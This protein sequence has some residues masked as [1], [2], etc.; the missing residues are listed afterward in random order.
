MSLAGG[1]DHD[2]VILGAGMSGI[3]MGVMLKRAG[4]HD[5]LIL[6]EA[7]GIGGTW[8]HNRYPGA[9]CDVPSHL[10]CFS[11]APNPDWSRV[12]ATG[13]EIQRYAVDCV[14]K[15]DLKKHLQLGCRIES[16]VFNAE[17]K[18]WRIRT[19]AGETLSAQIGRAH[20]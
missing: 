17:E 6:E 18:R 3:A 10:Y 2:V 8:W 14:E 13:D 1:S 15:F 9:Q 19:M 7:E 5:F 20:V 16:A 4:R 11:F 12:Y